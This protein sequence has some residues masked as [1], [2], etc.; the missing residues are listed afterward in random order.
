MC[1]RAAD[2][3]VSTLSDILP[4]AFFDSFAALQLLEKAWTRHLIRLRGP[5]LITCFGCRRAVPRY[6]APRTSSS[7]LHRGHVRS[8]APR[9]PSCPAVD[10][11]ASAASSGEESESTGGATAS[12]S[13][14]DCASQDDGHPEVPKRVFADD[15]TRREGSAADRARLPSVR[16]P[17]CGPTPECPY[18]RTGAP[19]LLLP[20]CCTPGCCMVSGPETVSVQKCVRVCIC[21]W[22]RRV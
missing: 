4:S 3:L 16:A 21:A 12:V 7:R 19:C 14:S 13:L 11:E 8:P 6:Q 9:A 10:S 15:G 20:H 17:S 2:T 22:R 18:C 1:V 5:A